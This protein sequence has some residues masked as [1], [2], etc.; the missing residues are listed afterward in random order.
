MLWPLDPGELFLFTHTLLGLVGA[1]KLFKYIKTELHMQPLWR[2]IKEIVSTLR[3]HMTP[4]HPQG[5]CSRT[6]TAGWE[7]V[8]GGWASNGG[9]GR[10]GD[11]GNVS[12]HWAREA[13]SRGCSWQQV[14]LQRTQ[15]GCS[16]SHPSFLISAIF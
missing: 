2:A 16:K 4:T 5:S 10:E 11:P 1:L 7:G 14:G 12:K 9:L 15:R 3:K 8:V 6:H 13:T